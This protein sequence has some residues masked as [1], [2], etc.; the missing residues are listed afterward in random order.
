MGN[1][2]KSIRKTDDSAMALLYEILGEGAKNILD[3]DSYYNISGVYHFVEF[4]KCGCNPFDYNINDN[5][6]D[7]YKPLSIIWDFCKR[8]DGIFWIV[9]YDEHKLQFKLLKVGNFNATN[10]EL[11]EE[12]KLTFTEF[13][14]WFQ[15]MNSDVLNSK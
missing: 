14:K 7:L 2:S 8:A 9:C 5:L 6:N 13:Q 15:K 1:E 12:S 4:I 11:Y 10:I 3:I